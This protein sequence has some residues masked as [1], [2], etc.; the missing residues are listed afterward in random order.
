[1]NEL[2]H[3]FAQEIMKQDEPIMDAYET[4]YNQIRGSE[5]DKIDAMVD[6]KNSI[7]PLLN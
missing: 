6:L 5:G 2:Q 4:A 7:Y 3:T 1:M